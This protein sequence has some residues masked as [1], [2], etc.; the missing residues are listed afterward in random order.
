VRLSTKVINDLIDLIAILWLL[1][2]SSVGGN[3]MLKLPLQA[4][5]NIQYE[6]CLKCRSLDDCAPAIFFA[7]QLLQA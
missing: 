1:M 5:C 4:R 7:W 2:L 3:V 6:T